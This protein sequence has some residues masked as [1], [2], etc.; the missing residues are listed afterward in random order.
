MEEWPE[1]SIAA[2]I[3]EIVELFLWDVNCYHLVE[4]P[5]IYY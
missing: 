3:V 2:T 5:E 1:G 4:S